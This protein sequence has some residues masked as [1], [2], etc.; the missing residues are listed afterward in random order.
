[1]SILLEI[2]GTVLNMTEYKVTGNSVAHSLLPSFDVVDM[3]DADGKKK[4]KEY[5][6]DAVLRIQDLH[7]DV[8]IMEAKP[9]DKGSSDDLEKIGL[10]L[11]NM[12]LGIRTRFPEIEVEKL[13]VHGIMFIGYRAKLIEAQLDGD[14]PVVYVVSDFIIPQ[15]VG[16]R[17][18]GQLMSALRMFIAFQR[19]VKE[20]VDYLL[21]A[22]NVGSKV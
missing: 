8:M 21:K 1:M 17:S 2:P 12:I 6:H 16:E 13:R 11:S 7:T 5:R 14:N 22:K 15:A 4:D 10:V 19:R 3:I 9:T 18:F 20:T